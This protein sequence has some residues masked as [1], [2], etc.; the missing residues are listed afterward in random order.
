MQSAKW[1]YGLS[2]GLNITFVIIEIIFGLFANSLALVSDALHSA[3]DVLGLV[4]AG[5]AV[6]LMSRKP[7]HRHTYG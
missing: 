6:W 3:G 2:I 1:R 4:L 5:F 7:S